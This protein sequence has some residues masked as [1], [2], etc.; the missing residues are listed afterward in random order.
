[1]EIN[2][3][4]PTRGIDVK[5]KFEI[6]DKILEIAADNTAILLITSELPELLYLSDEVHILRQGK[7]VSSFSKEDLNEKDILSSATGILA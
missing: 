5:T 2:K 7:I 4:E 6:H 1:M 3:N